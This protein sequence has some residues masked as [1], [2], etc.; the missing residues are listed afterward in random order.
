MELK[1]KHLEMIQN[2]I[3]RMASNSFILK[4]WAVT[5]VSGT[6]FLS[7]REANTLLFLIAYIPILLFWFLDS[8]Y[9]QLERKYRVL[10]NEVA[11]KAE[12]AIDFDLTPPARTKNQDTNFLKSFWSRTEFWFYFPIALLVAILMIVLDIAKG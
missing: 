8:Y 11:K 1:M 2:V 5:L 7:A 10:Y 9:L 6:F 3:T 12:N 4:G